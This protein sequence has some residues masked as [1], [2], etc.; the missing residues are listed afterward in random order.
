VRRGAVVLGDRHGGKRA[1]PHPRGGKR[2]L[3]GEEAIQLPKPGS[4]VRP[5]IRLHEFGRP[6]IRVA[7]EVFLRPILS[8]SGI[9]GNVPIPADGK[10]TRP[11][12]DEKEKAEHPKAKF[13]C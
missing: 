12:P 7:L 6:N 3:L 5:Q 8:V 4:E 11:E 13:F 9:F 10:T 1:S 2:Q